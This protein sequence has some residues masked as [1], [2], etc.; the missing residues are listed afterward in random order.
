MKNTLTRCDVSPSSGKGDL[1]IPTHSAEETKR[2][3]ALLAG[4][5]PGTINLGLYGDLGAGKTQFVKGVARELGIDEDEVVSPSFGL[6][7]VYEGDKN[8]YHVDLY[9]LN[10]LMDIESIGLEEVLYGGDGICLIEWAERLAEDRECLDLHVY[11]TIRENNRRVLTFRG[12]AIE[13]IYEILEP[14][15]DE[16]ETVWR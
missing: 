2:I 5:I 6:I 4:G 8:I 12:R 9:R 1:I 10:T 11:F 3:G 15:Q 13:I 16:K 7:N 14:Y